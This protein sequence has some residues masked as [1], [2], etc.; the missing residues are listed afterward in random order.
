MPEPAHLSNHHRNTLCQIF[1]HPVSH[2]IWS[3]TREIG[4]SIVT[5]NLRSAPEDAVRFRWP[6]IGGRGCYVAHK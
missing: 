4:K 1:Q 6:W 3:G 2:N 5:V